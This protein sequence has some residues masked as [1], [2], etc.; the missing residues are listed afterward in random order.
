MFQKIQKIMQE[1]LLFIYTLKD[2]WPKWSRKFCYL[3]GETIIP[4]PGGRE[5]WH[6]E[7]HLAVK[8]KKL[9]HLC[10]LETYTD[11][12]SLGTSRRFSFLHTFIEL[13]RSYG[14]WR[15]L[16]QKHCKCHQTS[17]TTNLMNII[18]M[19][20]LNW[21]MSSFYVAYSICL[22]SAFCVL[23]CHSLVF[24][25]MLVNM[26]PRKEVSLWKQIEQEES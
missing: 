7:G 9:P 22:M 18:W 14:K 12:M 6:Q 11:C 23:F 10:S 21:Q 5:S 1:I 24:C 17:T 4:I 8:Q 20:D 25:A 19:K 13:L 15:I 3:S 2:A 16:C 26:K